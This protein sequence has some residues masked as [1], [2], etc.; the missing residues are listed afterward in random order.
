MGSAPENDPALAYPCTDVCISERRTVRFCR[1]MSSCWS[2]FFDSK[3]LS[4][5]LLIKD[6]HSRPKFV[7]YGA[8]ETRKDIAQNIYGKD[9]K[10]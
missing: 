4:A 2:F 9:L 7:S 5:S 8:W 6:F 10:M 1:L 3:L